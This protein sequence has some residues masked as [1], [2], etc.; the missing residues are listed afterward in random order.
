MPRVS[1]D[2]PSVRPAATAALSRHPLL[3]FAVT[4]LFVVAQGLG[5][6]HLAHVRHA[7]CVEHGGMRHVEDARATPEDAARVARRPAPAPLAGAS[8][9]GNADHGHEDCST[10]TR[11]REF[12]LPST[13]PSLSV[14]LFVTAR[15]RGLVPT[16][17]RHLDDSQ[18]WRLAP[19]RGPPTLG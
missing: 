2:P 14:P 15:P 6:A 9:A 7:P 5:L 18:R 8:D 11:E 10:S 19:K 1:S 3:A 16:G 12:G 4:L 13:S 17:R